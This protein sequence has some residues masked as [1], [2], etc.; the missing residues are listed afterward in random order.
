MS[1]RK[2][3]TALA[4]QAG[5]G[6]SEVSRETIEAETRVLRELAERDLSD[7]E[8]LVVYLDGIQFGQYHVLEA[9]GVDANGRKARAG[10]VR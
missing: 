9:V 1:T 5:I 4:D 3:E 8:V 7:L 10:A 2:Y 6:K